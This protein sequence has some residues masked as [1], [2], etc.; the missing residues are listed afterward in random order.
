MV[1]VDPRLSL[2]SAGQQK[3]YLLVMWRASEQDLW[4]YMLEPVGCGE[5]QLFTST[6]ELAKYL[7]ARPLA[8]RTDGMTT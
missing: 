5:K 3:S 1:V 4:Q 7:A 8:G 6:E 2:P